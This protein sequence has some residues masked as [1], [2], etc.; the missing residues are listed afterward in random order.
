MQGLKW[1]A[2]VGDPIPELLA[3]KDSKKMIMA[4]PPHG[5]NLPPVQPAR[6][7]DARASLPQAS[8][9]AAPCP[10]PGSPRRGPCSAPSWRGR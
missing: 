8:P 3:V 2:Q 9:S 6:L 10:S 5:L 1:R 7:S 4:G